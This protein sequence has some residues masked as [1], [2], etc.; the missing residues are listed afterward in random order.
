MK[1]S[2]IRSLE[3]SLLKLRAIWTEV[4]MTEE[5]KEERNQVVITHMV[6]LLEQMVDEEM[7]M[8]N[9][10]M[11]NIK[12]FSR[13]LTKICNELQVPQMKVCPLYHAKIIINLLYFSLHCIS[14][15]IIFCH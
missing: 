9:K 2:I 7:E 13:E 12:D 5:Q 1:E 3:T 6:S 8:K 11:G 10:I 15:C 4:G 14:V